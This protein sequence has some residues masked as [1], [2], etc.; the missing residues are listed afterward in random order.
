MSAPTLAPTRRWACPDATQVL[1]Y[2]APRDQWLAE[3]RKGLGGSDASTVAGVNRWSSRFELWLDK[4]GQLPEQ[5]PTMAMR[6]GHMLEPV[7]LQLFTEETGIATRRAGLMVSKARPW[8]RVSVD[9]LSEDGGIVEAKTTNWR[10]AEE[11][12][13]DQ[14]AD[15]AEVQVQHA[16][17]VTGRTHAWVGVLIDG[18][19]FRWRR[20][21][22]DEELIA[23]L[24]AMEDTFWN[25]HVLGNTPPAMEA[26]SLDVVK[27]Q[28]A[29]VAVDS[30]EA[31]DAD[32]V[33]ALLARRAE[34]KAM[35]K[36]GEAIADTAEAS[37][38]FLLGD[39]EALTVNGKPVFTCKANG[40]FASTR[41]AAAEPEVAAEFTTTT[42]VLDVERLKAERPDLYAQHRA[43]VLRPVVTK[44]K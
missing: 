4:T 34:G 7:V 20:V 42:Q 24:I 19:D 11:W 2:D 26:N 6:L 1:R 18:R 30:R 35:V 27:E 21:E 36:A 43:R 8:Q 23:T 13:D 14:V 16:L 41:F 9:A 5:A 12:D 32:E 25:V 22:R 10:M 33:L 44:E 17:A 3:R 39:A 29:L 38:R 40:T 37:L 28:N 15:H 31:T